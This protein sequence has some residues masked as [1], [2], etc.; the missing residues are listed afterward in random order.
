MTKRIVVVV[1]L[2][3]FTL[4]ACIALVVSRAEPKQPQQQVA[5]LDEKDQKSGLSLKERIRL[6]KLKGQKR[7][8]YKAWSLS[9]KDYISFRDLDEATASYTVVIAQPVAEVSFVSPAD[10]VVT[11]YKFKVH[12]VLS[13]PP[14]PKSAPD[15][16][17]GDIRPELLPLQEGEFVLGALGGS[18]TVDDVEVTSKFDDF[19][20][21][22]S[23][24]KYLMF[25]D[26]DSSKRVAGMEMGPLSALVINDDGTLQTLDGKTTHAIK[27]ALDSQFGNS[28]TRVKAVI[29]QRAKLKRMSRSN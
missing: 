4:I 20:P 19:E 22:S 12:E 25:L 13:E 10:E 26:F 21:F 28:V 2:G 23:N 16:F 3:A 14:S 27:R 9:S 1:L 18:L 24:K 11:N 5:E 7:L 6:A 17:N 8:I 29:Q 15:T